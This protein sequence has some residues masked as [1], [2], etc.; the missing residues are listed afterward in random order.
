MET[1]AF[2]DDIRRYL[3]LLW[4]W[5][6]LLVLV[7]VVAG[8]AAFV[9]N[10]RTTEPIY[11]SNA[12]V[13]IEAPP[14]I[15][16]EYAAIV[17]SERLAATYAKLMTTKPILN[18][19]A[20]KLGLSRLGAR[21]TANPVEGTQF[22]EVSVEDTDPVRAAQIANTVVEVF[23]EQNQA[24][25]AARY[26]ASKESL[27]TQMGEIEAKIEDTSVQLANMGDDP[28]SQI[29]RAQLETNLAQYRQIYS[30]L[31]QTRENIQL[32][33][34]QSTFK[35]LLVEPATASANPAKIPLLQNT[36]LASV[37]GLMLAVGLVFLIEAIDDTIKGPDDIIR[38]LGLPIL[39]LIARTSTNSDAPIAAM[40]PRSPV[41][42]AFR[43][44]RTNIQFAS[45]DYPVQS[46]LIT[47]TSPSEGKTTVAANLG[48]VLAQGGRQVV[49]LD[50][51]LR[52]P[53][54][55]KVMGLANRKGLTSLFVQDQVHFDGSIK[56]TKTQGLSVITSGHL[57]PNPS[58]LLGS[59]KMIEILNSIKHEA[60]VVI[61]DTP[62]VMAVT[63]ATVLSRHVDAVL[64]VV[65][66]GTTRIGATKQTIEQLRR[67]GAHVLGVVLNDVD[68]KR[69]RYS[70]YYYNN[71]YYYYNDYY[72]DGSRK[73]NSRVG[74]RRKTRSSRNAS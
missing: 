23:S 58:E 19:V 59:D 18:S 62:P 41:T 5:A 71:G 4:H 35:V 70:Y 45:V 51:D 6:W 29:Q 36:I 50:A 57:P 42:E 24:S 38:H 47:S 32:T 63:D 52:R 60:D 33:E 7:T 67:I 37:V 44:L 22:I 20:E 10:Q 40:E 8:V 49:L 43:S 21:I 13:L 61:L 31:L 11:R 28:E 26:S 68:L 15:S 69:S 2:S 73:R 12:T 54:M 30:S 34:A 17:T 27:S 1:Q 53:R 14:T 39:G 72:G 48:V 55:H 66:P 16:S 74:G 56:Q 65:K 64:I 25:Q 3:S 9:I 46:L